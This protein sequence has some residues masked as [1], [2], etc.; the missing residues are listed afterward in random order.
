MPLTLRQR[1]AGADISYLFYD[2]DGPTVILL[3]ATG[4]IPWTWHPIARHLSTTYRVIVPGLYSHREASRETG[5]ISWKLLAE[6]ICLF[7]EMLKIERPFLVGHS[8]GGIVAAIACGSHGIRTGAMV[9]I[10]PIFLPFHFYRQPITVDTH[11]LAAKALR[12]KNHWRDRAEA[13]Q[14]LSS[15]PL[16]ASWNREVLD[17][18]IKHGMIEQGNGELCLACSPQKEAAL[19]MGGMKHN[20]WPLL[21]K[22]SCPVL[23]VEGETSENRHFID[24][25]RI[26]TELPHGSY[27]MVTN[28][29]HLLPMEQPDTVAG[30]I[31]NFFRKHQSDMNNGE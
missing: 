31:E 26:V 10:E 4:F 23:I 2:G 14:Y 3:H 24:L 16:F 12:R 25:T 27:R 8:M 1:I 22:L 18:Y 21:P 13:L 19:F 20:P 9:L 28:S 17:L 5:G 6:D 29:G 15:R 30:I 11:P 7:C